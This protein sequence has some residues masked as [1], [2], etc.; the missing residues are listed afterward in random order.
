MINKVTLIGNM[1][2]DAETVEG[3]QTTVTRM[4]LAT[5]SYFRDCDGQWQ[6]RAEFHSLVAFGELGERC[7]VFCTKGRRVYVEG[8]LRT[9]EWSGSDGLRR[10]TTEI[11]ADYVK[12]LD[13]QEGHDAGAAVDTEDEP[14]EASPL[15]VASVT[16]AHTSRPRAARR[17]GSDA[18]ATAADA[19]LPADAGDPGEAMAAAV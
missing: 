18:A 12:Y 9:R 16:A 4:R 1:T 15:A 6:K 19:T 13:S 17:S 5:H 10:Y 7:G 8:H 11:V 3:S 2:R 14:R